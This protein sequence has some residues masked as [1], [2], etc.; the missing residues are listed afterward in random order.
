MPG[1]IN[2]GFR[3]ISGGSPVFAA[4]GFAVPAENASKLLTKV[5]ESLMICYAGRAQEALG[6]SQ[7][8]SLVDPDVY[9]AMFI[10]GNL[11]YANIACRS[12]CAL[13]CMG[14]SQHQL[15]ERCL[16]TCAGGHGIAWDGPYNRELQRL[17][18]NMYA[19]NKPIAAVDHG[20]CALV[21][22][23]ICQAGHPD[24]GKSILYDRQAR[25][26]TPT[27][28]AWLLPLI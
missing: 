13:A 28:S 8:I 2:A 17:V 7:A 6:S 25:D 12:I 16:F 24:Q 23:C 14:A 5:H 10:A 26:C 19:N 21:D 1:A 3:S 11:F 22:A 27:A 18:E 4:K 15:L 20:P 9:A